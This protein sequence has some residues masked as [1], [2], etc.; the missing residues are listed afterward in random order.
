MTEGHRGALVLHVSLSHEDV[1][2][3]LLEE[4]HLGLAKVKLFILFWWHISLHGTGAILELCSTFLLLALFLDGSGRM[5]VLRYKEGLIIVIDRAVQ[6]LLHGLSILSEA[7]L[8]M[9]WRCEH[10][11][12]LGFSGQLWR[13]DLALNIIVRP[14]VRD[15]KS[16]ALMHHLCVQVL[17][18]DFLLPLS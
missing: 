17:S 4:L 13:E 12:V 15:R 14:D 9:V 16:H 18:L 7:H 2:S 6:R 11:F 1:A 5:D 10:L 3:S 8:L